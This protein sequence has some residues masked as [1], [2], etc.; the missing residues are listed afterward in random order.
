MCA[1]ASL[2]QLQPVPLPSHKPPSPR[3]TVRTQ[4][5][6][7]C[8]LI[9][10]MLKGEATQCTQKDH[11]IK[12]ARFFEHRLPPPNSASQGLLLF[13]D[14]QSIPLPPGKV[15]KFL[16]ITATWKLPAVLH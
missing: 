13:Q 10:P 14:L 11:R 3:R 5:G 4:Q 16:H 2:R 9:S 12:S 6:V 15:D 7:S 1:C 8:I